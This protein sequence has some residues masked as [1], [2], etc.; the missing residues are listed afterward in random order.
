L[1]RELIK[2]ILNEDVTVLRG[3]CWTAGVSLK[4]FEVDELSKLH[5]EEM[6]DVVE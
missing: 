1:T 2:Q 6:V 3:Y 4:E 5:G